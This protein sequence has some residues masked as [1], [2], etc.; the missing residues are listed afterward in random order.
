M[1][2]F[3]RFNAVVE[4]IAA[5]TAPAGSALLVAHGTILRL[6]VA[7]AAAGNA[8]ADPRWIATNPLPNTG[9]AVVGGVL[10]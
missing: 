2:T 1:D 6:W 8:G 5:D 10:F 9:L 3:D 4:E 7:L